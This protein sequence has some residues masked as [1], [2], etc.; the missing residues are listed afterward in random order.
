MFDCKAL[1]S[2]VTRTKLDITHI[3]L[4]RGC[5]GCRYGR[6]K[7]WQL[8][9]SGGDLVKVVDD[10]PSEAEEESCEG[11]KDGDGDEERDA[12]CHILLVHL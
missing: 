8:T 11:E 4:R 1:T 12:D 5:R 3:F 10:G 7:L 2:S 6:G 9:V